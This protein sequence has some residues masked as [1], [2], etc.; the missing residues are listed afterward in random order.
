MTTVGLPHLPQ[1]HCSG[2]QAM[3][4]S[5]R[6]NS[7]GNGCRPAGRFLPPLLFFRDNCSWARCASVSTSAALTPLCFHAPPA[8]PP[9]TGLKTT[10]GQ[11]MVLTKFTSGLPAL[12]IF[13]NQRCDLLQATSAPFLLNLCFHARKLPISRSTPSRW[14]SAAAYPFWAHSMGMLWLLAKASTQF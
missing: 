14:G 2:L 13:I 10:Q 9:Y 7:A 5:T 6:G 8:P 4:C 12:T 3:I 11:T 1:I